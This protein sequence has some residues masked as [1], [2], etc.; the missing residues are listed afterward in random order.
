MR[1]RL[2]V[3]LAIAVG[4]ALAGVGTIA[5]AGRSNAGTYT[6]PQSPFV[7][8]TVISSA[9]MNSQFGD[10]A[11]SLTE[12]LD[13]NGRGPMLAPLRVQNGSNTAPSLSF[14]NDQ[15][16]GL[17][18][19]G[20]ANP[21]VTVAGTKRQEWTSAGAAITGTLSVSGGITSGVTRAGM[22]A[23]GQQV[24]GNSGSFATS[25]GTNVDVTN[26]SVTITTGGRPV[27]LM[28]I[29]YDQ[30]A[31]GF[32]GCQG[33]SQQCYV[34]LIRGASNIATWSVVSG[35]TVPASLVFLDAPAAGTYTYKI[36]GQTTGGVTGTYANLKLIAYEL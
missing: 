9:T 33:A 31:P 5:Y 18:L 10:I 22:E 4:I 14:N 15:D 20:D 3:L 2:S 6:L 17:Y 28:L 13:R 21:A 36:Q 34:R 19:V 27:V 12:S 11:Q 8:G 25:S 29:A 24:S 23:V 1:N 35:T 7:S 26:L 30:V 16:T 32:I